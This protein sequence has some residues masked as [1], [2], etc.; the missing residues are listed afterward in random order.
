M[1]LLAF[2]PLLVLLSC[3]H[4]TPPDAQRYDQIVV[5][6]TNDFHGYLRPV[7]SEFF[8]SKVVIGGAEWLA[9]HVRILERKFGDRL[10]MLDGG[11]LFQGTI[12]SNSFLGESVMRFYNLLPYR[13]ASV[14]NHEFDYGPVKRGEKDRLGALKQRMYEAKFPFLQANIFVRETGELW[15]EK[16]LYPHLIVTAGAY[17]IGILGLTTT[18]TP[19]KTLPQNVEGLDFR[20]FVEPAKKAAAELRAQGAEIVMI[21]THEGGEHDGEPIA[22]LLKALPPGTVDA[23]VSGHAHSEIHQFVHGV[24]VIQSKTR[25]I[26]FGRIDLFVDK[27]TRKIEL[28]LTRIHGMH[29]NCGTWFKNEEHCDQKKARDAIAAGKAK[30]ED[31]L[32]LRKVTYEGEEVVPDRKVIEALKPYYAKVDKLKAEKLGSAL[33]DFDWYPSGETQMGYLFIDAFRWKFPQAKVIYLNGG[34]FRRRFFKGPIT[35]G[36]L[37]EVHPFDNFAGMVRID[38]KRLKD[39]LRVGVSG[40]PMIPSVWGVKLSYYKREDAKF[41]RDLNGDGKQENWERDRLAELTWDDGRPVRDEE[42]FWLATNDYL[43][44]GGDNT[45]HVFDSAQGADRK[46]IDL[47]QRDL[48]AEYLRAHKQLKLPMNDEMRVRAIP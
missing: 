26:Y 27:V 19:G 14:G 44:A 3:A 32:P 24:P 39:L 8:G 42:T 6:G 13:A 12:E 43:L 25:G 36:D 30:P 10:V 20:D 15:R 17:K 11:D 1:R 34:G 45:S 16:N 40:V 47:S 31:Y 35:Y 48:A 41:Q 22:E 9:G 2:F 4:N 38:G 33:V 7:E 21:T 46:I 5:V 23:V 28:S 37:Y 18:T 29:W